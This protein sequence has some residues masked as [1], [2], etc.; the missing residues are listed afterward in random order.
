MTLLRTDDVP[1]IWDG[2]GVLF[3]TGYLEAPGIFYCPSHHGDHPMSVYVD[4]WNGAPGAIQANY[5]FRGGVGIRLD[6]VHDAQAL[7]T[8]ALR[9]QVDYSHHVG[10]NVLRADFTV[11]WFNDPAGSLAATL[12]AVEEGD[13]AAALKVTE[14]WRTIDRNLQLAR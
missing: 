8:D 10:S 3:I 5:Q 2:L 12:P 9:S 13:P 6:L 4:R 14:A 11:G 7:V 1:E